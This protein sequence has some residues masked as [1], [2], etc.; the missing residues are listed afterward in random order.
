MNRDKI[1][2]AVRAVAIAMLYFSLAMPVAA[3]PA[4]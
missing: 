2:A 1:N 3:S 4:T